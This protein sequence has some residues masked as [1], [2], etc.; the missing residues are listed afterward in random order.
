MYRSVIL[1]ASLFLVVCF[2][3]T[4][5]ISTGQAWAGKYTVK[6]ED[7]P[8]ST[9]DDGYALVYI[10]RPSFSGSAVKMWA[11]A[12]DQFLGVTHGYNYTF[13]QVPAGEH[14]L[15]S[16]SENISAIRITLEAG[17]TYYMRQRVRMGLFR[18]ATLVEIVDE[19]DTEKMFK[20]CSYV[21]AT[22]AAEAK[23]KKYIDKKLEEARKVASQYPES[24]KGRSALPEA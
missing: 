20:K 7:K 17:K 23:A 8:R 6:H 18:A 1:G 12:D 10:L 15:W 9:P 16:K 11:F 3:P 22:E 4:Q 2:A 24:K 5:L 14:V 13:S 19:K 21:T